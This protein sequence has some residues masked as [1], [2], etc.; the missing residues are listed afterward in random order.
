MPARD[1]SY[2]VIGRHKTEA[3]VL[4]DMTN[5]KS[6]SGWCATDRQMVEYKQGLESLVAIALVL[7]MFAWLVCHRLYDVECGNNQLSA[8]VR[9][10]QLVLM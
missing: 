9:N 1:I 10:L 6:R 7:S 4:K 3:K 8:T 5:T 2:C